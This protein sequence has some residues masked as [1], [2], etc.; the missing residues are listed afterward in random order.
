AAA[1]AACGPERLPLVRR[2]DEPPAAARRGQHL[3]PQPAPDASQ[4]HL[5]AGN[6]HGRARLERTVGHPRRRSAVVG[7]A[8]VAAG[9]ALLPA[10][11]ARHRA[12][13][14]R[15]RLPSLAA[16]GLAAADPDPGV[17]LRTVV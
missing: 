11:G 1:R 2:A 3:R 17:V 7:T 14:A 5:A 15:T 6:A 12:R 4:R 10:C 9:R 16:R 8:A 13:A